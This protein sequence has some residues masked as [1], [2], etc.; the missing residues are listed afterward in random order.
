[1]V[2]AATDSNLVRIEHNWLRPEPMRNKIPGL[3]LHEKR[4]WTVDGIIKPNFKVNAKITFNN[5]DATLDGYFV[6]NSEDSIVVMYRPASDS[7]WAITDSF[8]V[9][10]Q[11]NPN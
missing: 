4:Y 8:V 3:H 10:M 9:N 1:T 7:E 5:N 2:T 11:G 6:S